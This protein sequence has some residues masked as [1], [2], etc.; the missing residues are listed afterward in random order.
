MTIFHSLT[1]EDSGVIEEWNQRRPAESR[2]ATEVH[3]I[4][5][6]TAPRYTPL[7]NTRTEILRRAEILSIQLSMNFYVARAFNFVEPLLAGQT[8]SNYQ[9]QINSANY[10]AYKLTVPEA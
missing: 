5:E 2:G 1:T 9:L 10:P 4:S 6:R 8:V 7:V 3:S